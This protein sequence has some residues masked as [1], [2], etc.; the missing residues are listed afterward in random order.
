ME[1][2]QLRYFVE[3]A[4]TE[5]MTRSADHLHVAQPAL[6]RS[7]HRLEK[8]LGVP[9]FEHV[10]RN[11]K[12]T[13]YGEHLKERALP[14]V[15]ELDDIERDMQRF[16][17]AHERTIQ[18]NIGSGSNMI[19]DVVIDYRHE[20]SGSEFHIT[21]REGRDTGDV[22][23]FTLMPDEDKHAFETDSALLLTED[24]L[25]AVPAQS[26]LGDTIA[27]AELDGQNLVCL[28]GSRKFRQVCDLLCEKHGIETV[29]A[30][31]SDSPAV[32]QKMI[33]LGSGVGFW[34]ARSWPAVDP[35]LARLV[36]ID[37]DDFERTIVIELGASQLA[38]REARRFFEFCRKHLS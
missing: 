18:L 19:L 32:V 28:A 25:L 26:E 5:H 34:P 2:T 27:P 9:L 21:Q 33:G 30:F 22:R 1:F 29:V 4:K 12:L 14:L 15:A 38:T 6:T 13:P 31:E 3:V 7:I 37:S 17:E 35:A 20:H 11:I 16:S 10:G 36:R 8:E 24:I 23:T